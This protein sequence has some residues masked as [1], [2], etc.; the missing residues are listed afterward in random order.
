M[1]VLMCIH[2]LRQMCRLVPLPLERYDFCPQLLDRIHNCFLVHLLHHTLFLIMTT[3]VMIW[4]LSFVRANISCSVSDS[5]VS[6]AIADSD[7]WIL[8]FPLSPTT[9]VW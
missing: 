9:L 7:S 2:K 4:A 5:L 6:W 1:Q 3:A 8:P